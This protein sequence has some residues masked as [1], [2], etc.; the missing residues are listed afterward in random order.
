MLITEFLKLDHARMR[1]LLEAL[2]KAPG[3][4][5]LTEKRKVIEA[6]RELTA[7]QRVHETVEEELLLPVLEQRETAVEPQLLAEFEEAHRQIWKRLKDL[8]SC[9]RQEFPMKTIARSLSAYAAGM[10]RHMDNEERSLF[11]LADMVLPRSES[12]RLAEAAKRR[13]AQALGA[14]AAA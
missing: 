11:P 2:E 12:E 14:A 7:L 8:E 6:V 4:N 9:A 10:R 5:R 13:E 3:K 1:R